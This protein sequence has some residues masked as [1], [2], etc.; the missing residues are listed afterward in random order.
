[1]QHNPSDNFNRTHQYLGEVGKS[2]E[3]LFEMMK[4]LVHA[5][6]DRDAYTRGHSDRVAELSYLIGQKL[7]FDKPRLE[8]LRRGSLLHDIGKIGIPDELLHKP[9]SF[10]PDERAR[11][12]QHPE[13]GH[14]LILNCHLLWDLIPMIRNHHENFDGSGYPDGLLGKAISIEARIVSLSD[15]FDALVTAR[16]YKKP[17]ALKDSLALIQRMTGSKFDPEVVKVFQE[18]VDLYYRQTFHSNG[19]HP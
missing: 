12:N 15:Y 18:V 14:F 10:S 2:E 1:M 11:M 5:L 13:K 3:S 17:F 19:Q 9:G 6:E 4:V 16:P 7:G 8:T